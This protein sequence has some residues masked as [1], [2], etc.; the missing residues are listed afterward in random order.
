[1]RLRLS[2]A[3]DFGPLRGKTNNNYNN[4]TKSIE[5]I[6]ELFHVSQGYDAPFDTRISQETPFNHLYEHI[7]GTSSSLDADITQSSRRAPK[8]TT[9]YTG[10]V[11]FD[12]ALVEITGGLGI[13]LKRRGLLLDNAHRSID[14]HMQFYG[15]NIWLVAAQPAISYNTY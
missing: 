15:S 9:V 13:A 14:T 10:R 1:M 8:W 11:L 4:S 5:L 3:V 2:S 12:R 6:L 7:L